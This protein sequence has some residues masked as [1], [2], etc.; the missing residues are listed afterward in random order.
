MVTTPTF[1]LVF[2]DI[3]R[4]AKQEKQAANRL[5]FKT[6]KQNSQRL[7]RTLLRLWRSVTLNKTGMNLKISTESPVRTKKETKKGEFHTSVAGLWMKTPKHQGPRAKGDSLASRESSTE[8]SQHLTQFIIFGVGKKGHTNG[9]WEEVQHQEH[10]NTITTATLPEKKKKKRTHI[11][12]D[13]SAKNAVRKSGTTVYINTVQE[14]VKK[15]FACCQSG[16]PLTSRTK[17]WQS[18]Q[19]HPCRAQYWYLQQRHLL[20][21]Y[22]VRPASHP[23]PQK[24]NAW[25]SCH[26]HWPPSAKPTQSSCSGYLLTSPS[27]PP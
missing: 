4:Q 24:T 11:Y 21:S 5:A 2:T 18:R 27:P 25:T 10:W 12:T 14:E 7:F 19:E 16:T 23:W 17:E 6:G 1:D 13:G 3:H 8:R 9:C 26:P 15:A 22:P 20:H